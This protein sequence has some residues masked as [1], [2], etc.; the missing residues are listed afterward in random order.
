MA[1]FAQVRKKTLQT[2][3]L[4]VSCLLIVLPL[5]VTSILL[6][7]AS[8]DAVFQAE[9][10]A[11]RS[12]IE[13]GSRLLHNELSAAYN[14]VSTVSEHLE[15]QNIQARGMSRNYPLED[16]LSDLQY[17]ED[18]FTML[19]QYPSIYRVRMTV[20]EGLIY[21]NSPLFVLRE[22]RLSQK[23]QQTESLEGQ[24][25]VFYRSSVRSQVFGQGDTEVVSCVKPIQSIDNYQETIGFAIADIRL[26]TFQDILENTALTADTACLLLD[27]DGAVIASRGGE[28]ENWRPIQ[29]LLQE[30]SVPEEIE[31]TIGKSHI[32]AYRQ[33]ST[34]GWK[35]L[36]L[37]P[38]AP[39]VAKN[40]RSFFLIAA[41]LLFL[42]FITL[43]LG[44]RLY[45]SLIFRMKNIVSTMRLV[46]SGR[47]DIYLP[48]E[49]RDEIG[50]I[51]ESYNHMITK[52][53]TSL[54][55]S[56]RLA[57]RL[58][59]AEMDALMAR[60]DPHFLYNTLNTLSWTAMD[61]NAQDISRMLMALAKYYKVCLQNNRPAFTVAEEVLH[62]QLYVE[63]H[64]MRYQK[65]IRFTWKVPDTLA[66]KMI[67]NMMIQ[68]IIE[69][70]VIHG[71]LEKPEK[72]GDIVLEVRQEGEYL[73]ISVRDDGVGVDPQ[74]MEAAMREGCNA[75]TSYGLHNIYERLQLKYG[76]AFSFRFESGAGAGTVVVI[77]IPLEV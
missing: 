48:Q 71:I 61:Y 62:A 16:Q 18:F 19:G 9:Q 64:N 37:R 49:Q 22:G 42:S 38:V 2:R 33:D 6:Y 11:L 30:E 34:Y 5:L 77:S 72:T 13:E 8:C 20:Q 26:S 60:I 47:L 12:S 31:R 41:L 73:V 10:A 58:N 75:G 50:E 65:P 74:K 51:E 40:T 28:E 3:L 59:A 55:E 52:L 25:F 17:T 44:N 4:G 36:Y 57:D 27:A 39:A 43:L 53:R 56:K 14:T 35:L 70:A 21:S 67:P 76:D 46:E 66:E 24:P 68:P 69:N 45:R 29:E 15:I 23:G 63:I 1:L 7:R 54:A 32:Y